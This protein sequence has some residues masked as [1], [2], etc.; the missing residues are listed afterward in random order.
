MS[1]LR[2]RAPRHL[3]V[4]F[5]AL[6]SPL[7][8]GSV[9]S[10]ALLRAIAASSHLSGC[11]PEKPSHRRPA[12]PYRSPYQRPAVELPLSGFP[13]AQRS[14]DRSASLASAVDLPLSGLRTALPPSPQ[15]STY[16]SAV[17]GPLC[18]PRLSG[19][20][21]AQRSSDRSASLASASGRPTAERVSCNLGFSWISLD[22]LG[23]LYVPLCS[24]MFPLCSLM[25]WN[26]KK[27]KE[28]QRT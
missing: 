25:F 21:I 24:F 3:R 4:T 22:F 14:S 2:L 19:R 10:A 6:L 20:P 13:T 15:R 7:C 8:D 17:F 5:C 9:A 12:V 23:F 26:I 1:R 11:I 28:I 16:R 27:S 18:L